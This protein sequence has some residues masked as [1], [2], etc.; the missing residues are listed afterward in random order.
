MNMRPD[1]ATLGVPAPE[2]PRTMAE[3]GLS[4][5]M[6]R[7]VLLK[8]VFRKSVETTREISEALCVTTG[9]RAGS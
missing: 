7:D 5:V 3:T 9:H 6:L 4:G 8:T 1:P 2:Q